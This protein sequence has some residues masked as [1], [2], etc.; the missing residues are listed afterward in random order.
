MVQPINRSPL[1]FETQTKKLSRWFWGTNHQTVAAGF[2]SQIGK[3]VPVVL[4]PN[5]W[6]TVDLGF[7]AKPR[8]SCSSSP[9]PWCR[10]H[11]APPNPSIVWPPSTRPIL[12]YPWSSSPSLLLLPRSS[13]LPVMSHLSHVHHETSKHDSPHKIDMGK[14]TEV[15][16][17]W[18]QIKASQLLIII[19]SRYW[20]LG[21]STS[22]LC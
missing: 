21:F 6:Q 8:N 18:I 14:T 1:G 10:P 2:E 4:S 3:P 16:W 12:D 17:I 9:C 22:L 7:Q 20:P 13:S 11:T 5:H 15:F 19:K